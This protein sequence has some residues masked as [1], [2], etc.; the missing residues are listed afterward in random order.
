ME[1]GGREAEARVCESAGEGTKAVVV[2]VNEGVLC[3]SECALK[4]GGKERR[5][6]LVGSISLQVCLLRPVMLSRETS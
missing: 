2:R 3:V 5:Q 1:K 6:P 4:S